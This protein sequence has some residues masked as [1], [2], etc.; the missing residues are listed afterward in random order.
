MVQKGEFLE[1][2]TLIPVGDVVLEGLD[3]PGGERPGGF[4]FLYFSYVLGMTAQV[5]D[6]PVT[7]SAMRRRVTIHGVFSF[8]FNTIIVAATVNV[9]VA[10]AGS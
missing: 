10:I 5:A 4:D 1:R 6:V 2:P 9:V 7:S 3:F 8:F